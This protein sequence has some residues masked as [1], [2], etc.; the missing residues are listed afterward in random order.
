MAKSKQ[1]SAPLNPADRAILEGVDTA[2]AQGRDLRQWWN[3]VRKPDGLRERFPVARQIHRPDWNYGFLEK[4]NLRQGRLPVAGVIQDQLYDY[5]K[6]PGGMKSVD[7]NW[8]RD[9]V[10]EFMLR[11]FMRLTHAAA[12]PPIARVPK[13]PP[14]DSVKHLSM[15]DEDG[16]DAYGWGYEQCYY[17]LKRTSEIGKFPDDQRYETVDLLE[18]GRKYS[19]IVYAVNIF[20]FDL[21]IKLA[22]PKGPK[23]V[24]P[25]MQKVYAVLTP[26]YVVSEEN[27]R[28]GVLGEYGYG[29]S[30][31][32]NPNDKGVFAA[33]PSSIQNT[34]ETLRLTVLESGEVR[35]HMDFITPLP[36][37]ILDF[38]PVEWSFRLADALSFGMASSMLAP[39]KRVAKGFE[40]EIAPVY[41]GVWL[42]NQLTAG[43]ASEAFCINKE[44]LFKQLMI[45][46]FTDVYNMYNLS[47]SHFRMVP[48]WTDAKK[49][50][51]W[52]R[53]G[54]FRPQA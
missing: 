40:P 5:P 13:K 15:C 8:I 31:V 32:P 45:L 26:D 39:L 25:Q 42:L 6:V 23:V 22:G 11:Y 9:Q 16:P 54:T 2:I 52:A 29:Y 20:H 38:E 18:I 19:W 17:K 10:K 28:P 48:D 1:T 43:M 34:L 21:T 4:A 49:V 51:E 41:T 33:G 37:R 14:P 24:I 46:H 35:A 36:A 53:R 50:P 27:P 7:A 12:P 47:A 30:V 44:Q 3:G